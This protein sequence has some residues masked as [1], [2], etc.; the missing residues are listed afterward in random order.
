MHRGDANSPTMV[1]VDGSFMPRLLRLRINE[2]YVRPRCHHL[3][4]RPMRKTIH[5][6]NDRLVSIMNKTPSPSSGDDPSLYSDVVNCYPCVVP[7]GEFLKKYLKLIEENDFVP[8]GTVLLL[9]QSSIST[10]IA[11]GLTRYQKRRLV[12]LVKSLP[13]SEVYFDAFDEGLVNCTGLDNRSRDTTSHH[14]IILSA[15]HS[16]M[17]RGNVSRSITILTENPAQYVE[18]HEDSDNERGFFKIEVLTAMDFVTRVAPHLTEVCEQLIMPS[19]SRMICPPPVV[20][21]SKDEASW[22]EDNVEKGLDSGQLI[23]G[24]LDVFRHCS[25]EGTIDGGRMLVASL[26]HAIHRDIVAV[27]LFPKQDWRCPSDR[28]HLTYTPLAAEGENDDEKK[29]EEGEGGSGEIVRFGQSSHSSGESGIAVMPT[30]RV[31]AVL[32]RSGENVVATVPS[33]S[34]GD[35]KVPYL[36]RGEKI[37]VLAVPMDRRIPKIYLR[38]QQLAFL[39]GQRLVVRVDGWESDS[40][41]PYG[42]YMR[43]LGAVGEVS[44]E[45]NG[46]FVGQEAVLRPFSPVALACLPRTLLYS[47]GGR[48]VGDNTREDM[49]GGTDPQGFGFRVAAAL[50]WIDSKWVPSPEDLVGRRDFRDS[51][52]YRIFSVDPPGCQDID[53]A[54]HIR[55]LDPSSSRGEVGEGWQCHHHQFQQHRKLEIGVHIADVS[56]FVRYGSALD[57]EARL[58][59]TSIYLPH[60]RFDMLPPLLS[61][62]VCS[63]QGGRD[64]LAVSAI[65]I[66]DEE[67]DGTFSFPVHS[68]GSLICW[69]GRTVIRSACALTYQQAAGLMATNGADITVGG[70]PAPPGQ[71]GGLLPSNLGERQALARDLSLLSSVARSRRAWRVGRGASASFSTIATKSEEMM[72]GGEL[73][74]KLDESTGKPRAV[75]IGQRQEVHTVIEELVVL[76]NQAAAETL[77]RKC[78]FAALLR[79]HEPPIGDMSELFALAEGYGFAKD[80]GTSVEDKGQ[81]LHAAMK[82]IQRANKPMVS[83]FAK[84][85]AFRSMSQAKYICS[86]CT[87]TLTNS[88]SRRFE[89]YGL[90]LPAYTHFTSPIRRYVDL[91]VH[92]LLLLNIAPPPPLPIVQQQQPEVALLSAPPSPLPPPPPGIKLRVLPSSQLPSVLHPNEERRGDAAELQGD[93]ITHTLLGLDINSNPMAERQQSPSVA[94][95]STSPVPEYNHTQPDIQIQQK[96]RSSIMDNDP[97]KYRRLIALAEYLNNRHENAKRLS[98]RAQDIFLRLYLASN[99]Y[100]VNAVVIQIKS[101]GFMAYI[102]EF[103]VRGPVFLCDRMGGIQVLCRPASPFSS[104]LICTPHFVC[105]DFWILMLLSS[106][107]IHSLTY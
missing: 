32:Q 74:F 67:E 62:D 82:A 39:K 80:G 20:N 71:A 59:G 79:V 37:G 15:Q 85:L 98:R 51:S 84:S 63:L 36:S 61:S 47:R 7:D 29:T 97:L 86:G 103:N 65:F 3:L 92:R 78:P 64:R 96:H 49:D 24:T 14:P 30:G 107:T 87:A 31:V 93:I 1:F 77:I 33:F 11:L 76:S 38:T 8:Q 23:S 106:T 91:E 81:E 13:Y 5:D 46:L 57:N 58:K 69:F 28:T 52:K 88:S 101:N 25:S 75:Y 90:G 72:Y 6:G 89:H 40:R 102:P 21:M 53:D 10:A 4:I 60:R 95:I 2:R 34:D 19:S 73:K 104:S 45:I 105:F 42:H 54:M 100:L 66:L 99:V 68:D 27:E 56:W 41:Y 22:N 50:P 43:R 35:E 18:L 70:A 26:G 17:G 12:K 16:W 9:L 83:A 48:E 44:S 94:S 55:Y